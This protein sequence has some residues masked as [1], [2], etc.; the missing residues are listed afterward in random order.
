MANSRS[1][2]VLLAHS[3]ELKSTWVKTGGVKSFVQQI[4]YLP[5][6]PCLNCT[7]LRRQ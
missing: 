1:T 5:S 4:Q 2:W 3:S 6:V 7:V